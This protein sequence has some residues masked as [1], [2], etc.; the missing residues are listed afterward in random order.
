MKILMVTPR[1]FPYLGG[2]ETHVH[3]VGQRLVKYGM[4]IT[5]LTTQPHAP[6]LLQPDHE[7]VAGMQVVRVPAWPPQ[8]DYYIAPKIIQIIRRGAWDVI[9]CQGCHT[10]VPLLTMWAARTADKPYIVTFHTGGHSSFLRNRLR[11]LQWRLLCPFFAR[12]SRL[13]G[14]SQFEANYFCTLLHLPPERFS[15]VPNGATIPLVEQA[16][17]PEQPLIVSVGRLERYKGHHRLITALPYVQRKY[18]GA[19]LLIL[20][21]GPYEASL[22]TWARASGVQ[23][24]VEIRV[25]EARDRMQMARVLGQASVVALLSAY[26]SHPIAILE[27]VALRRPV[28][29]A[30]TSGLTELVEQKLV[31]AIPFVSTPVQIAHAI[32]QQIEQ[33]Y[34]PPAS[35]CLPTWDDC[36]SQLQDIYQMTNNRSKACGF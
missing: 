21:Q 26:E 30:N 33:P 27:A 23:H 2:I 35:Y 18:P 16:Y 5:L 13:I 32:I 25:L 12:A 17:M 20:G 7:V 34:V 29:V 3:E 31:C 9:H 14:V 24:A 4:D 36:A 15:V 22:R 8:R 1:Y 11:T 19:Q 28:L 6:Y 10:F